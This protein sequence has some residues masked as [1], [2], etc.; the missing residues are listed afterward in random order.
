MKETLGAALARLRTG[1]CVRERAG[2]IFA[3]AE[4]GQLVHFSLDLSRLDAVALYVIE[5]IRQRYPDF[6]IPCH[7]RWRHFDAGGVPRWSMLARRLAGHSRREI[8]RRRFELATVSVLLDAGAGS[9]WRYCETTTGRLF[10]RSEGLAIASLELFSCG[11]FSTD[12]GDPLRVDAEVLERF[13]AENLA[14]HLQVSSEN[15]LAGL[16]GRAFLLRRLGS[17]LAQ[18]PDLF[19]AAARIGNL[20]DTL[21]RRCGCGKI[22]AGTILEIVL[23]GLSPV[24][25]GGYCMSGLPLGDVWPHPAACSD[26]RDPTD[27]LVPFHKLSQWLVYSLIEP[28]TDAG[29]PVGEIDALTGLPEYRN[30][31]LFIDLGVLAP[32]PGLTTTR[33][34]V[35]SPEVIEWRALT[36]VLLDRLAQRVRELA[37]LDEL[38]LSRLLEGGSWAAGRRI[39]AA[40]RRDAAPPLLIDSDGT[41]F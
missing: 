9:A 26:D 41:V 12:P 6:D 36:V 39:A 10:T 3:A 2:R 16:E 11:A 20:I 37:G 23:E 29:I 18:R 8:A 27:G 14:R 17:V 31:G 35:G 7:S 15:P 4:A 1:A 38:P 34:A 19:G 28:L 33:H 13:D 25:P 21:E 40:K 24:W 30:G 32:R 22:S 5:T